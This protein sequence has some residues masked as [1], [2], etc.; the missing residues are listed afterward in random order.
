MM[1][2]DRGNTRQCSATR[3]NGSA[4]RAFVLPDSAFCFT[5]DPAK[6]A[7]REAR[8]A[9]GGRYRSNAARLHAAMP[10]RLTAIYGRLEQA[11]DDLLAGRLNPRVATA[12]AA[13]ASAM[14][15]VFA[16]GELEERLRRLEGQRNDADEEDAA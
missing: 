9:K 12:A 2:A 3:V 14:V 13:L 6:A 5:H 10:P 11:L 15:R 7:E 4:C 8:N 16:D 1:Q